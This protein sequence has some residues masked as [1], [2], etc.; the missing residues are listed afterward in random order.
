MDLL[1][2]P[3]VPAE[4]GTQGRQIANASIVTLAF[5]LARE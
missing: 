1:N 2:I 5:P 3:L 4:A